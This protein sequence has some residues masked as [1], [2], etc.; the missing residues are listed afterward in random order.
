MR[1]KH[2]RRSGFTL[3]EVLI[4]AGLLAVL[5]A[6]VV[7]S[8]FGRSEKVKQNLA[9]A[10]VSSS[11]PIATAIDN[12][13]L[14]IGRYPE[15]LEELY[16]QPDDDEEAEK[17]DPEGYIKDKDTLVD[18]WGEPYQYRYPG[19]YHENSYDLWSMGTDRE[20]D[21]DDDIVNWKTD[22]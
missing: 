7:P 21:T 5:A 6:F 1:R 14:D 16:T 4:V 3:L 2:R 11:G 17:W 12:F 9:L 19:E 10:A 20:D 15:E 18:P 8:L 22:R 13:R